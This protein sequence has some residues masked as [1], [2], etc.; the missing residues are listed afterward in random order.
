MLSGGVEPV[1]HHSLALDRGPT[2]FM[3]HRCPL[4]SLD[5]RDF[6]TIVGVG[7]LGSL[8]GCVR[9]GSGQNAAGGAGGAGDAPPPSPPTE[10]P[11]SSLPAVP[12]A[13]PG[14][15][16]VVTSAPGPTQMMALTV[17]DGYCA[18]C[19]TGYVDFAERTGVHLTF[20]PNGAYRQF[21]DPHAARLRP[22]IAAGQVQVANHTWTHPDVTKLGDA[23]LRGELERNE[24]WIEDTFGITGRPYFRPPYGKHNTRTDEVAARLGYTSILLWNGT[25]GDATLETPEELLGLADQWMKAGTIMLGHANHPTVLGLFGQLQQIIADRKLQPVTIDAMFGTSRAVG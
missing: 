20:L 16:V 1:W 6:L 5:R 24:G 13:R 12:A 3:D 11:A 2:P 17:D 23:A 15:P 10:A 14:K 9:G 21:W 19:V 18:E 8:A 22:L 25:L 7:L 4:G